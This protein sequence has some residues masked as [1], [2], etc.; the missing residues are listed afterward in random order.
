M[1]WCCCERR[2]RGRGRGSGRG[3]TAMCN[4]AEEA[5]HQIEGG[6][7]EI[8]LAWAQIGDEGV[9][10]VAAALKVND[11]VT[12]LGCVCRDCSWNGAMRVML[13]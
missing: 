3:A 13:T 9:K 11:T 2:G 6:A 5:V 4:N 1:V 8:I 12:S 10:K 7:T